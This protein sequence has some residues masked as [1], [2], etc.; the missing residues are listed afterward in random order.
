ESTRCLACV[1]AQ[2]NPATAEQTTKEWLQRPPSRLCFLLLSFRLHWLPRLQASGGFR[3]AV[4]SAVG[5]EYS[6]GDGDGKRS[7]TGSNG[8][9]VL[10]DLGWKRK[11]H[12]TS[13]GELYL[14]V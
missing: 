8:T 9:Q 14:A 4:R 10:W 6:V 3:S 2:G 5:V 1:T 12:E 7:K 11:N 13:A